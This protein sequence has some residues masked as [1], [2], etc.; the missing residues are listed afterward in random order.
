MSSIREPADQD[1]LVT[2]RFPELVEVQAGFGAEQGAGR[3][4]GEGAGSDCTFP[5]PSW[6]L[7]TCGNSDITS[8]EDSHVVEGMLTRHSGGGEVP[9][10]RA[11]WIELQG[12]AAPF[13]RRGEHD[14]L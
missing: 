14:F 2:Q 8:F 5:F 4:S 1:V 11:Y 10:V 13:G 3:G 9:E 7:G 6:L 12:D